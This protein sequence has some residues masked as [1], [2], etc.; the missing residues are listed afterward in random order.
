MRV[1]ARLRVGDGAE[2][3]PDTFYRWVELRADDLPL[4]AA[5][6][7]QETVATI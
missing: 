6:R 2:I 1:F 3:E 5:G 4:S 7:W